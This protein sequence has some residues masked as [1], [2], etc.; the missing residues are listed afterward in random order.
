MTATPAYWTRRHLDLLAE[1]PATTAPVFGPPALPRI[2]PGHDLWD[3]WPIQDEDGAN[4]TD[5]WMALSA[6]ALG[7]PEKRH[8][9]ARIRLLGRRWARRQEA[10]GRVCDVS[11]TVAFS[12]PCHRHSA[13][14]STE[15]V[16]DR[17]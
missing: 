15:P 12:A 10:P 9:Q 1:T 4:G 5:L 17:L 7:H 16:L 2:L 6:P 3:L 14:G 13:Y 8:D 11:M